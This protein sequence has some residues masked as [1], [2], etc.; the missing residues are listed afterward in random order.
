MYP[1]HL[2]IQYMVEI[3]KELLTLYKPRVQE[4]TTWRRW[5]NGEAFS[6]TGNLS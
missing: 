6:K 5:T 1:K 2:S 3:S 4:A